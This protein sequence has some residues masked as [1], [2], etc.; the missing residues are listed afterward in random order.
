[1]K[2]ST[3]SGLRGTLFVSNVMRA[4]TVGPHNGGD[5]RSRAAEH[6]PL[7]SVAPGMASALRQAALPFIATAPVLFIYMMN[8]SIS[9]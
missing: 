1:M 3:R 5:A 9:R 7:L 4:G 2:Q 6:L 8:V